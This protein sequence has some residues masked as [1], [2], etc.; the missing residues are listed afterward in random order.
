[1]EAVEVDTPARVSAFDFCFERPCNIFELRV[2]SLEAISNFH[3]ARINVEL[4]SDSIQHLRG[5]AQTKEYVSP[6]HLPVA[7]Y[8]SGNDIDIAVHCHS[9]MAVS[10]APA[11]DLNRRS[12]VD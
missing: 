7:W 2:S 9:A 1:S 4:Q 12:H 5:H 3:L 8:T 10:R 6:A 11:G